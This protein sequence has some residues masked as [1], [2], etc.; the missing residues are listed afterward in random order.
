MTSAGW[1]AIGLALLAVSV[2]M[3]LVS[4]GDARRRLRRVEDALRLE[5]EPEDRDAD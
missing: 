4:L 3:T 1:C 5:I 2:L